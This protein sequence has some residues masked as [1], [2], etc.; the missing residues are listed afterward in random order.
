VIELKLELSDSFFKTRNALRLLH[1]GGLPQTESAVEKSLEYVEKSWKQTAMRSFKHCHNNGLYNQ[2]IM[3]NYPT[4]GD[5]L[6]GEVINIAPSARALEFGLTSAQRMSVLQRS[7]QVRVVKSGE[8]RG[9]K[10]LI[11]P[12]RHGTPGSVHFPEMPANVYQRAKELSYSKRTKTY[13]ERSQQLN[14]MTK[15]DMEVIHRF[16]NLPN[17]STPH[18]YAGGIPVAKR[19]KYSYGKKLRGVGGIYEGMYKFGRPGHTQYITFLTM[20]EWDPWEGIPAYHVAKKTSEAVKTEVMGMLKVGV[21][22]DILD[23]KKL[24]GLI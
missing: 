21:R 2:G 19:Y 6:A 14:R 7:H 20:S 17:L 9:K 13:L 11:I 1:A 10:F 3:R 22:Q 18:A 4:S 24:A 5:N 16:G 12:F 15:K 8:H 23:M